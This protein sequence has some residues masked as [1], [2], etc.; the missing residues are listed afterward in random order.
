MMGPRTMLWG[1]RSAFVQDPDANLVNLHSTPSTDNES[2]T[3]K[4]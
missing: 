3:V 4:H 1:N 2:S